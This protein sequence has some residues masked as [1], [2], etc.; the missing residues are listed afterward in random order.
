VSA[1]AAAGA[2]WVAEVTSQL[3][4]YQVTT[5][6]NRYALSLIDALGSLRPVELSRALHLTTSGVS[7]LL[8]RM[9]DA[10]LMARSHQQ[11]EGD[12]KAVRVTL[13]PRGT[14]AAGLRRA[15][16]SR[17]SDRVLA[18][19]AQTL[20]VR[21][22]SEGLARLEPEHPKTHVRDAS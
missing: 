5:A 1:V 19:L 13:T 7:A 10:G 22:E 21:V 16:L 4:P 15:A 17:H 3:L 9:E 2:P 8:D 20:R 18:A 12:R 6:T 14:E 11:G